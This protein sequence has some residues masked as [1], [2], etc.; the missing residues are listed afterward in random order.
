MY[1][2]LGIN[3]FL[4]ILLT[5][6]AIATLIAAGVGRLARGLLR[7]CSARTHAELLFVLR[8]GPPVLAILAIVAFVVP[9][10]LFYEPHT[11]KEFVSKKL[12]TLAILSAVGVGLAIW[13]GIRSWYATRSLLKEWLAL[14]TPITITNAGIAAF[15]LP[16]G[17]PIIAV[18]GTLRPR[19]FIAE[20]VLQTLSEEELLAAIA[21]ECGH[22]AAHDNFKRS[23]LR[24][25]RAALLIIPCGRWLDQAWAEASE[26]AADEYAAQTS[27]T[28]ALNLASALVRIARLVPEGERQLMPS[29][30]SN[31]LGGEETRGVK[32]RVNRLIELASSDPMLRMGDSHVAKLVRWIPLTLI[33]PT[34]ILLNS[35]SQ[36]LVG[37]HSVIERVVSFLS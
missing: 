19:L 29:G 5:I 15:R 28:V 21:H 1:E 17:F 25:S 3:V 27:S 13:R 12:A 33:V 9:S 32:S 26:C 4:A 6:N 7:R 8:I 14:A 23:L 24:A 37:V 2:L 11:T 34:L 16:Y 18:V 30:V 35:H 10:Y 36:V 20:H 31:F 22:L